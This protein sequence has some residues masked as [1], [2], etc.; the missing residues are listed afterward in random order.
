MKFLLQAARAVRTIR[1]L[2][3]KKPILGLVGDIIFAQQFQ[4]PLRFAQVLKQLQ[5]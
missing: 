1:V 5:G 3:F 2:A 4:N